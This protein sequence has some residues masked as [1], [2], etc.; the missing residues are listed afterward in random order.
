[1]LKYPFIK[2]KEEIKIINKSRLGSS[3]ERDINLTN[4]F[5]K[6]NNIAL[7]FKNEIPIKVVK[8]EYLQRQKAKIVE[9]YYNLKSLPDYQGLYQGRYICFDVKETNDKNNFFL[10]NIP[11][12]QINNLNKIKKFNGISFFIIHFKKHNKYFYLPIEF[13]NDYIKN[14]ENKKINFKIFEEKLYQIPF[15]YYP[16][17][18]YI[19]IV[20][21]FL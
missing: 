15:S 8:V 16:R 3:L 9:A 17:I 2:K 6:E 19:E 12:H 20:N 13:L 1:M 14:N 4:L 18:N 7:I 11:Q 5:Y 21:F 10:S